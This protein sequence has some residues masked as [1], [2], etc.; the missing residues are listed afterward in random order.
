[1][2]GAHPD[3]RSSSAVP[4]ALIRALAA[5]P[6][7]M[8]DVI[9]ALHRPVH[10]A[11][12]LLQ[13]MTAL[14]GQAVRL[15]DGVGWAGITVQFRD[16]TPLTAAHTDARVLILDES[17]Y[18]AGDGPCLEAMRT[19]R[20]VRADRADI[21]RRW[22]R[23][24]V[25][26]A[27]TGVNSVLAVPLQTDDSAIGALNLYSHQVAVPEPD[28]DVATVL[29]Q[30][31]RRGLEQYRSSSLIA[32]EQLRRTVAQWAVV[33]Q[34]VGVLMQVHGFSSSYA[35]DVLVDQ[36]RDWSRTVPEQAARIISGD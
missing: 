30:Y 18:G 15:L 5:H 36:A 29:A 3:F 28:P 6:E 10:D 24:G 22:P 31:A 34:A 35:R 14:S 12:S 20:V 1:V 4:D 11:D 33:E 19:G 2:K 32:D 17:Q 7:Q 16:A 21:Q 8:A 23:L 26:A 9:A 25:A 27:A 13:L